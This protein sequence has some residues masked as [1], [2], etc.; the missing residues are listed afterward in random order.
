MNRDNAV[1]ATCGLLVGI[2][3]GGVFIGPWVA[4]R[5]TGGEGQQGVS[6]QVSS[7]PE[8]PLAGQAMQ[9][10]QD[11]MKQIQQHRA[12]LA[13]N[14]NDVEALVQLGNLYMDAAKY[15][16]AAE[17]YERAIRIRKDPAVEIDLGISYRSSGSPEKAL[18]IFRRLRAQNPS[19]YYAT[20]NEA[21]V[22]AD[23]G[24]LAEAKA[25]LPVLKG[26]RPADPDV[27]GFEKALEGAR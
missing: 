20:F 18:E 14:P 4:R 15:T 11:V 13:K 3:I 16:Q 27:A 19:D 7:T 6:S 8:S 26:M 23:L 21:I 22:L 2:L 12:S 25:L 1:F 10:M 24:K 5:S 17:F 9:P